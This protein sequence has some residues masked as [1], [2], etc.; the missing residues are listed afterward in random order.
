MK[1]T[2]ERARRFLSGV[3]S[4]SHEDGQEGAW[5]K[6]L[7]ATIVRRVSARDR[8]SEREAVMRIAA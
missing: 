4:R 6:T 8:A 5:E 3:G 2:D 1:E 7:V